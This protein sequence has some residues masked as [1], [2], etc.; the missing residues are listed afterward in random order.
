MKYKF[1]VEI[2]THGLLAKDRMSKEV[3]ANEVGAT[4]YAYLFP[5]AGESEYKITIRKAE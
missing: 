1:T 2:E 4:L 5:V 3:M